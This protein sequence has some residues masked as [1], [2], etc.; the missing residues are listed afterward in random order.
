MIQKDEQGRECAVGV[1]RVTVPEGKP[2]VRTYQ[3]KNSVRLCLTIETGFHKTNTGETVSETIEASVTCFT[4][5][6]KIYTAVKH[7]KPEVLVLFA[8]HIQRHRY[9]KDTG[10]IIE[11]REV[12]LEF[13]INAEFLVQQVSV[14]LYQQ[15]KEAYSQNFKNKNKNK[16]TEIKA[17]QHPS[18]DDYDF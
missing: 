7:I 17:P 10:E 13:F 18:G 2:L 9:K 8:G 16:K 3:L 12:Q 4:A 14:Q 1:G 5:S 6:S 11:Q 15:R